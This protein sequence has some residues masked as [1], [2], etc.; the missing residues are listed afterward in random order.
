MGMYDV[1]PTLGNMLGFEN[2]YALG[3]DIFSI[4]ENEENVVIFP[5]GNFVTDTVYYNNQKSTYFDVR[6]YDNVAKHASCNQSYKDNPNPVYNELRDGSYKTT[7]NTAY[8]MEAAELRTNDG[9]VEPDYISGYVSYG[10]ERIN[11]SN[12]I[13]YYDMIN[14][15][16]EDWRGQ[17]QAGSKQRGI[18]AP[19]D[20]SARDRLYAA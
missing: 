1:Q 6:G 17:E 15:T 14:K 16:D 2:S 11:I 3:H 12:A 10:E 13:I 5:N 20:D 4:P 8:S 9:A 18:F 19:P 7:K